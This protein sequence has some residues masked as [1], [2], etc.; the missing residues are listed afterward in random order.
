MGTTTNTE[1]QFI[2]VNHLAPVCRDMN[3][4]VDF[5]HG[6]LGM[7]VTMTT[8]FGPEGHEQ[9]IFFFDIGGGCH[10]AFMWAEDALPPAPG[11]ASPAGFLEDTMGRDLT[12]LT[13]AEVASLP[14][15]QT[16]I[17]S[18]N[19]LALSVSPDKI[20]EYREKL[21]GKGIDVSEVKYQTMD[22]NCR[23]VPITDGSSPTVFMKSI[24][25]HDPNG[26]Q[27]EFAAWTRV[28]T[29]AE[30]SLRPLGASSAAALVSS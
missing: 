26:I 7:P 3:E 29:D 13:E 11:V 30:A 12:K 15:T 22:E 27:L 25:F 19:H 21:V 28:M 24:Y 6:L 1:F 20:D 17:G 8:Q 5:Y 16:A 2:G 18:M 23:P 4:T 10:L 14:S 9:Q